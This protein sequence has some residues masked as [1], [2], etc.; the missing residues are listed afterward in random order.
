MGE[1]RRG[2][3]HGCKTGGMCADLKGEQGAGA[4]VQVVLEVPCHGG[5]GRGEGG[6]VLEQRLQPQHVRNAEW[7]LAKVKAAG[8]Q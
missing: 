5:V 1:K 8:V 4:P 7:M 2:E 6:G 3:V